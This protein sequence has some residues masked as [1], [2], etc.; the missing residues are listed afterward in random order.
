MLL[1]GNGAL[2]TRNGADSSVSGGCAAID[3]GVIRKIGNTA[4][5]CAEFRSSEFIDAK[6]GWLIIMSGFINAH[7][8]F[9]ST[10]REA[11]PLRALRRKNLPRYWD[12]SDG[13][14]R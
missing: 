3:G 2:I 6:G 11:W 10:F 4:E 12:V 5:M 14:A 13:E 9:Y 1:A 7:T 8:R